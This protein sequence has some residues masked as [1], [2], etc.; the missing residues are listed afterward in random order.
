M[1]TYIYI[2][3]TYIYI[4]IPIHPSIQPSIHPSILPRLL[5]DS[6]CFCRWVC[7]PARMSHMTFYDLDEQPVLHLDRACCRCDCCC[8]FNCCLCQHK[9]VVRDARGR[10]VGQ[11]KERSEVAH[12]KGGN[13]GYEKTYFLYGLICSKF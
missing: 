9:M 1:Y 3:Y 5:S 12:S 8:C 2:I 13:K 7:G 11:V 10:I 6:N 4:Y